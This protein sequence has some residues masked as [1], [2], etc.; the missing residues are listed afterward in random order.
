M[1]RFL[2]ATTVL[3]LTGGGLAK[4]ASYIGG[5]EVVAGAAPEQAQGTVFLDA[6]RNSVLDPG[7]AEVAGVIVSNGREVVVTGADGTYRLP[8][9]GDMNLFI[10]QP[11]GYVTPV[12]P[13]MVP[14]FAYVHKEAGSP[15]LRFGGL[16]PTG[17][18]PAAVNFPLIEEAQDDV[19]DCLVFGDTQPYS[20]R[21]IGYVRDTVGRMLA[22]RDL[23]ETACLIFAGDVMGDD[24]SLYDRFKEIVA[25]G[26]TPQYFVGGN[27]DVDFDAASDADSF[28]TFRREWGPEYWAA[29]IGQVM[30]IGL[31]NVRYPCN[32]VDPHP[33]CSSDT[34]LTYNGVVSE[35]QLEWLG[36]FLPLVPQERLIV[37]TAHIPFQTFTDHNAAKHQTDNLDALAALLE[38]RKVLALAGHTHTTENIEPGERFDGWEQHTNLA[39][40]PFHQIV[41]GAVSGSWWAGDLNDQGVPRSTQRLGSPRGYYQLSFDGAEYVETYHVFG[42]EGAQ[43]HASFNTPR[44]RHWAGRLLAYRDLYPRSFDQVPPVINRDLGDL[45]MLTQEDLAEGSWVAV[46]VWN[47]SRSATVSVSINEG[48]ALDGT[49]T[50]PGAGEG[51]LRG[52]AYADPL[53]IWQQSTISSVAARS[54]DGGSDTE[55]Y[56]TW[57]GSEW[58]GAVGP[59]HRWMLTDASQHLWRVDLPSDLPLGV[60]RMTVSTTDRH[61]RSFTRSYPFEVVE[62]LP[63]PDWRA[64]LWD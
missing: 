58:S 25:V 48:P 20:N 59:Y 9:Y 39:G 42:Q 2:T 54:V 35:R 47:G 38:G 37:M 22:E 18:L 61:G 8:A 31:D 51:K 14:Q 19:F 21:E 64:E 24:L 3:A 52:L 32:G 16:E 60:H 17:P 40:A 53:A 46:N 10:T 27:H 13:Q 44:F 33:F 6:N 41:T 55:G 63:N 15:D 62:T 56:T 26:R 29:E 12:S 57:Q 5:V 34:A 50:Q 36:N 23:S 30:F 28:D 1:L 7:E 49:R 4:D 11:A 45:Y 43:L